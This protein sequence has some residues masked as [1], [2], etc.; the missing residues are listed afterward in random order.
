MWTLPTCITPCALSFLHTCS[1]ISRPISRSTK[2]SCCGLKLLHL[3]VWWLHPPPQWRP[4]SRIR[5]PPM[6]A[7]K[8]VHWQVEM[9]PCQEHGFCNDILWESARLSR[10][11]HVHHCVF[12]WLKET[13]LSRMLERKEE[14]FAKRACSVIWKI[15]WV[16]SLSRVERTANIEK[17]FNWQ[18]CHRSGAN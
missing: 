15:M 8:V 1:S 9:V 5:L 2:S 6:V 7:C 13:W 4:G 14:C 16:V 12:N 17:A 11:T 18:W 10:K 3:L